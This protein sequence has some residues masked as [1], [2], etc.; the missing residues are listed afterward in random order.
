MTDVSRQPGYAN[1]PAHES[2]SGDTAYRETLLA[3]VFVRLADTLVEEFDVVEFLHSVSAD[4]VEILGAKAVGVMLADPRGALRLIASSE[5]RMRILELFEIQDTQGPCLDAFD[6][7]RMVQASAAEGRS[8]WPL[9]APRAS[10]A[11]FRLMCAIPLQVHKNVIGALNLLRGTDE[12]FSDTE[13][14]IAH[15][16]ADVAAIALIQERAA[17][18]RTLVT[19]QVEAALRSRVVIEQAKGMLAEYLA[20]TVDDAFQLLRAYARDN[21]R[22]LTAVAADVLDRRLPSR[23]LARQ[24]QP[25]P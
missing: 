15:A 22:K 11:G 13:L 5:E 25:R 6:S 16:M 19:G 12:P 23:A 17:R 10:E 7:G 21:N 9:F 14:E 18:E 2:R 24:P 1:A 4:S 3:R 8:R 20:T